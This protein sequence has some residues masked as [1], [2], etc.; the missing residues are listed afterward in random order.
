MVERGLEKG[1]LFIFKQIVEICFFSR[2]WDSGSQ[3]SIE[4][5]EH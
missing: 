2:D 1:E 3:I 5:S 4:G